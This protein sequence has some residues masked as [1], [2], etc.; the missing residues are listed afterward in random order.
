M[1]EFF[2]GWYMKIQSDKETF[3]IIPAVHQTAGK[4]SCSIQIITEDNAW[5]IQFSDEMFQKGKDFIRID[6]NYFCRK[7]IVLKLNHPAVQLEGKLRFGSLEPLKY[8]IMG[9]FVF[10]PFME[11]R[12]S[13]FSMYH[14]VN[15][16]LSLNGT[17]H[18]FDGATGYWE[19]DRGRSFP[20]E[21]LWT[22]CSFSD[23]SLM[24][25]LAE[26]P[27]IGMHFTGII[28]VVFWKG[29]E[30]RF[31]TYL[32]ARFI[33]IGHGA[34]KIMQGDMELE[35]RLLEKTGKPLK[36]PVNGNMIRIIHE[37]AACRAHYRFQKCGR[38]IF[39]FETG[40]ASFEYEY[41]V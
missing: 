4:R 8:D 12:H 19:G 9:P 10:A 23:G 40:K 3:A 13:V 28:G 24:L 26:I 25:S 39:A 32:G 41:P 18:Q 31:A 38:T 17:K 16:I 5:V 30:Y 35:A 6:E 27:V 29:R 20:K 14:S 33:K 37:S 1:R 2:E 36:A 21:Y 22:Q 7:G 34:V 15:G 11:C